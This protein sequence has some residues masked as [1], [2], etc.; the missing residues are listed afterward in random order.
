M[1]VRARL[2]L[3]LTRPLK[4]C[5]VLGEDPQEIRIF[6]S[7]KALFAICFYCSQKMECSH[8]CPVKISNKSFLQVERL[9][10]EPNVFPRD[11]VLEVEK[12]QKLDD[13]VILVFPQP[14]TMDSFAE[15]NSD[16]GEKL[17]T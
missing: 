17:P 15:E 7:Y 14:I 12:Q 10:N 6:L 2:V 16:Q 3:D 1:F 5:L 9:E 11:L 13:D 8:I 4:R